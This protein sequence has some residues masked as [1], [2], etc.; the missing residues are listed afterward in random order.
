MGEVLQG[1]MQRFGAQPAMGGM[2]PAQPQSIEQQLMAASQGHG[3]YPAGT[4]WWTQPLS[5]PP[6]S[7]YNSLIR[8]Y[9][10]NSYGDLW[11]HGSP[12]AINLLEQLF[13]EG[14]IPSWVMDEWAN[15]PHWTREDLMDFLSKQGQP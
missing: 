7:A 12:G 15:N 10:I 13:P 9:I 3:L 11:V 14:N 8:D 6:T 1:L 2:P 5:H 4:G